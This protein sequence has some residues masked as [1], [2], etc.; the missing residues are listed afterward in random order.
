[1]GGGVHPPSPC[2]P[3]PRLRLAPAAVFAACLDSPRRA[4][5][6]AA[7]L[8]AFPTSPLGVLALRDDEVLLFS[9]GDEGGAASGLD[10]SPLVDG[11]AGAA[12]A[13][14]RAVVLLRAVRG[15]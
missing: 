4:W 10:R 13:R 15:C 6:A 2:S 12:F 11:G 1:M 5:P 3:P 7:E 8:V 14:G 9:L